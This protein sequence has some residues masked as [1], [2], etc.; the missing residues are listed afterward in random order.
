LSESHTA[1]GNGGFAIDDA[2]IEFLSNFPNE[3]R[4]WRKRKEA[5]LSAALSSK[6]EAERQRDEARQRKD[7]IEA[8]WEE[9]FRII[10]EMCGD[11]GVPNGIAEERIAWACE[12][13]AKLR[14]VLAGDSPG[15]KTSKDA[16]RVAEFIVSA[17]RLRHGDESADALVRLVTEFAPTFCASR[18]GAGA[19]DKA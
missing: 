14:A 15:A 8:L 10:H 1:L 4:L 19:G 3:V 18:G 9:H 17:V 7:E 16:K 12:G 11:A 13:F 5:E 6:A 2:S